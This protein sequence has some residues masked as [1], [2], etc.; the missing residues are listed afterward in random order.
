VV[1][2][3]PLVGIAILLGLSVLVALILACVRQ[4]QP[5]PVLVYT[6]GLVMLA[7]TTSGLAA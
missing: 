3:T 2:G 1:G 5:L 4:R 7:L 6:L